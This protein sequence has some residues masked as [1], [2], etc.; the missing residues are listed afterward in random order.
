MTKVTVDIEQL[1]GAATS[2][3]SAATT[4]EEK[5]NTLTKSAGE[6]Y[7]T[8]YALIFVPSYVEDLR[9]KSKTLDAKV[10]LAIL[11]N[12]GDTG[13]VPESGSISYE[14]SGNDPTDLEGMQTAI[15]EA[16]ADMGQDMAS[17]DGGAEDDPRIAL[18]KTYLEKW[19]SNENTAGAMHSQLGPEGTLALTEYIGAHVATDSKQKENAKSVL[20]LLKSSLNTATNGWSPEKAEE[21][22]EELVRSARYPTSD[23]NSVPIYPRRTHT[24]GLQWLL[25]N[26]DDASDPF[27]RGVAEKMDE[28]QRQDA[29]AN[30]TNS[31]PWHGEPRFFYEM[32]GRDEAE[33]SEDIPSIVFHNLGNRPELSFEFFNGHPERIGYWLTEHDHYAAGGDLSG[34]SSAMAAASTDPGVKAAHPAEA[35]TLAAQAI[36]RLPHQADT[37]ALAGGPDADVAG[38]EMAPHLERIMETYMPS[39]ASAYANGSGAQ[40]TKDDDGDGV[41]DLRH[42]VA[43][44]NGE[45]LTDSPWFSTK[46]L[47]VALGVIGRD[48]QSLI[49]MRQA[50]NKAE[51]EGVTPEMTDDQFTTHATQW[52]AVEGA[53]AN[54]VGTGAIEDAQ[55]KDDYALAWIEL[56]K[57]AA[58]EAAGA[59]G[60][61]KNPVTSVGS[62]MLIDELAEQAKKTWANGAKSETAKQD[63]MAEQA[64][65]DYRLRLQFAADAA[66][67]NGYQDENSGV[68]L[69]DVEP[70]DM[71][72]GVVTNPDG[73]T[74][75]ITQ[76]ELEALDE[77]EQSVARSSLQS[78]VGS[79]L[80]VSARVPSTLIDT[81]FD[82]MFINRFS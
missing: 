42:T 60:A 66:G 56:G 23:P 54:A 49:D 43:P 40:P 81:T 9:N 51:A 70:D 16:M 14:V 11:I 13:N 5:Y 25:Y 18:M 4:I 30:T 76:E 62:G 59:A 7:I 36:Q 55:A 67:L 53:F 47:D 58:S 26:N 31:W 10:D 52:S 19:G 78:L 39:V 35:A 82:R 69:D 15:G 74:R 28:I 71:T 65:Q 75:L 21:F 34:I 63:A 61:G 22:G 80:G 24:D 38:V 17:I 45:Q 33:W 32:V 72:D 68:T 50:V 73:T 46:D 8:T 48:R 1:R 27:M 64:L 37:S 29:E 3:S 2:L 41:I 57:S 77:G 12:S 6:V 20:E 44:P 79:P